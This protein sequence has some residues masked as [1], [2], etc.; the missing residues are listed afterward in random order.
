MYI[1]GL[2]F[3]EYWGIGLAGSCVGV[4]IYLLNDSSPNFIV[5][6]FNIPLGVKS[7]LVYSVL[8]LSVSYITLKTWFKLSLVKIREGESLELYESVD[9]VDE[10]LDIIF[11]PK[12]E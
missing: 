3:V 1:E 9:S 4:E 7:W 11:R 8:S 10:R 5:N 12:L 6:G 2:K